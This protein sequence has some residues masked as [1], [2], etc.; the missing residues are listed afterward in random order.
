MKVYMNSFINHYY[1]VILPI[2]RSSQYYYDRIINL[3]ATTVV[4]FSMYY[5]F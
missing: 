3:Y 5:T 1:Y 4:R 2:V